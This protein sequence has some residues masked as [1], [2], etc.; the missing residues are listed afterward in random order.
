MIT[1]PRLAIEHFFDFTSVPHG[2]SLLDWNNHVYGSIV[3][4]LEVTHIA[5]GAPLLKLIHSFQ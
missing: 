1:D 3:C 2:V 5:T 4:V